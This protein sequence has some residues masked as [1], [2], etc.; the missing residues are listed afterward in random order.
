M[1]LERN[2]CFLF[3]ANPSYTVS[4]GNCAPEGFI[5]SPQLESCGHIVE[6][7]SWLGGR[8]VLRNWHQQGKTGYH[9]KEK[10]RKPSG[11]C[12]HHDFIPCLSGHHNRPYFN[13]SYE[14]L[15]S[16][17]TGPGPQQG[18]APLLTEAWLTSHYGSPLILPE[19]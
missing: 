4:M 10:N 14:P 11:Q 5:L 13:Y 2:Q 18:P 8:V 17:N 15:E 1:V 12:D 16:P 7:V 3:T 19:T 9:L 6:G